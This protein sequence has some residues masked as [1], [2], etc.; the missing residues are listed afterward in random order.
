[1]MKQM[2]EA[3]IE[4]LA[5]LYSISLRTGKLPRPW[6]EAKIIPIPKKDKDTYRPISLLPV[7]GKLVEKIMLQRTL[8]IVSPHNARARGFKPALV[9][10]DAFATLVHD[11]STAK[12]CESKKVVAIILDL[13]QAFELVQKNKMTYF[14]DIFIYLTF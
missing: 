12:T 4:T 2:L 10:R 13:R 14:Y 8:W 6:K 9:T 11:M 7:Q 1:M 5:E 3:Y